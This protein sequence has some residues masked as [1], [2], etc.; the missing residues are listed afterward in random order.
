MT[1]CPDDISLIVGLRSDDV[2]AVRLQ[3]RKLAPAG[4]AGR[5]RMAGEVSGPEPKHFQNKTEFECGAVPPQF[6]PKRRYSLGND[7]NTVTWEDVSW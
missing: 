1:E 7:H 6:K 5:G 3:C 4:D 2:K